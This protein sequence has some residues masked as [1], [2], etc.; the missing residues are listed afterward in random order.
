MKSHVSLVDFDTNVSWAV[1][2]FSVFSSIVQYLGN[3]AMVTIRLDM[4]HP[5]LGGSMI[6]T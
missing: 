5:I 1:L 4:I 3:L 2:N 6:S